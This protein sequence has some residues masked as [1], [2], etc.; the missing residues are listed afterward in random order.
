[1]QVSSGRPSMLTS[2]QRGRGNEPV[3]VLGRIRSAV[4]VNMGSS[5]VL[6]PPR[7]ST[8]CADPSQPGVQHYIRERAWF[9]W[10]GAYVSFRQTRTVT[11][12]AGQL[13]DRDMMCGPSRDTA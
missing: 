8:L 9:R 1:M 3:T 10:E 2:N 12:A 5:V 11:T 13:T 6:L 7:L 4:T